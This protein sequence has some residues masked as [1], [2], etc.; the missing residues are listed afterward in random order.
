MII[1]LDE[2]L[3]RYLAYALN[4]LQ[5]PLNK[6]YKNLPDEI[7]VRYLPDDFGEGA[8]DEEWIP[9]LGGRKSY[10]ITSDLNIYRTRHQRALCLDHNLGVF[11]FKFP[12]SC[13]YWQIVKLIIDR[14]EQIIQKISKTERPFAFRTTSN[15]PKFENIT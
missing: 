12:K 8:K 11:F 10:V 15:K 1:Y 6:K 13:K 3:S 4:E 9:Q 2:N 5:K 7:E 14:W